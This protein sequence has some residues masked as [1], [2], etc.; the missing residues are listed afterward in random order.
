MRRWSLAEEI[1]CV[2]SKECL[3]SIKVV[4]PKQSIKFGSF[5]V[6]GKDLVDFQ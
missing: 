6:T 3:F 1:L 2:E 4:I 5:A